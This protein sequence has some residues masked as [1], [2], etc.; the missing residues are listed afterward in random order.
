VPACS[1]QSCALNLATCFE[2]FISDALIASAVYAELWGISR[3]GLLFVGILYD[4]TKGF[5]DSSATDGLEK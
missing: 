4:F 5:A 3:I 1:L 2:E